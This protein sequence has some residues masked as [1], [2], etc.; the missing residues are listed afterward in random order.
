MNFDGR[1][2][3]VQQLHD[4]IGEMQFSGSFQPKFPVL[5]NTS[6][7]DLKTYQ[8]WI[9][10]GKPTME[11]WLRNLASYYAGLGW[12]SMPHAFVLPD[13]RVGLGA[14]FNVRGTHTP[15]WNSISIGVETLGEFERDIWAGTPTEMAATALFGE[16]C[17]K[18]NWQPDIYARGVR[19]IHFHKEDP[20]TTHRTCPGKNVDKPRFVAGVLKYMG[21]SHAAY[22]TDRQDHTDVPVQVHTSDSTALTKDQLTSPVWLQ[23]RLVA[24]GFQLTVDGI[25][26]EET[27]KAVKAFQQ[28]NPPLNADG[29]AGPL[30]RLKLSE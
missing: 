14:P 29:I 19:G 21:D 30:T 23:Q 12:S 20:N 15:S 28:A 22:E 27:K 1:V 10:A 7:P 26:G 17:N 3:T 8:G 18:L 16:L 25:I 24:K 6:V 9:A 5:H 2:L 11:Q 4:H 13:G